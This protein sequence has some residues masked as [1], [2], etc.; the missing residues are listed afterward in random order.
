MVGV[1]ICVI[2]TCWKAKR[3]IIKEKSLSR[4]LNADASISILTETSG[5]ATSNK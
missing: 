3:E 5:P 4:D 2:S 1:F